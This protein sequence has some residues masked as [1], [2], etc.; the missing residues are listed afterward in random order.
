MRIGLDIGAALTGRSGVRVYV[1][2]LLRGLAAVDSAN[3]YILYVASWTGRGRVSEL[4]LP[5]APNFRL[6]TPKAPQRLLLRLDEWGLGAQERWFRRWGL[7]LFHG[8]AHL[9]PP[10]RS[11]GSVI[12][13]HHVGGVSAKASRWDRYYLETLTDRCVRRADA[14]IAVSGFSGGEVAAHWSLPKEKLFVVH[15]GGPD[16]EFRP[17]SADAPRSRP[18]YVL[19]VGSFLEHKNIATL[20]KAFRLWLERDPGREEQLVLAG[21]AGRDLERIAGLARELGLSGRVRILTRPTREEI[22][23][24]YQGAGMVVVPSLL[25][26]F[27]F[28]VLEAMASGVPAIVSDRGAL[29]E[30]AGGA[31]LVF[32]ALDPRA[33]ADAMSRLAADPAL[34]AELRA[35]GARRVL[36]FTWEQA[37]LKTIEV[38]R[39]VAAR[40]ARR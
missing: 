27:G 24:L 22:V 38:Y 17:L 8:L 9:A 12:T 1:E 19:H 29:A 37:A 14:V 21:Q 36:E 20:V 32:D 5:A 40:R 33:L 34:A 35:K 18:P 16:P 31:A 10:L 28:P 39:S 2:G 26:G 7:D 23:S 25:E 30:I 3:E 4:S 6:E 13:V 15:E 11:M